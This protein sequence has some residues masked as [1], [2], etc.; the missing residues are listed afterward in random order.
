MSEGAS[1]TTAA[2]GALPS[3]IGAQAEALLAEAQIVLPRGQAVTMPRLLAAICR[4]YECS[5]SFR[6]LDVPPERVMAPEMFLPLVT[7][8]AQED[9]HYL[10]GVDLGCG[11]RTDD[12]SL[13]GVRSVV[14]PVTGHLADLMRALFF[15]HAAQKVF[16]L[17]QQACIDLTATYE[18]VA[19]QFLNLRKALEPAGGEVPWPQPPRLN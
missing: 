19:E 18:V 14:P 3:Q 13:F 8:T 10:L 9:G 11:I 1:P 5:F 7:G 15:R 6:G 2:P 4:Q 17:R 16:G 12:E